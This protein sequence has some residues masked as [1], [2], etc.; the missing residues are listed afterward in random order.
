PLLEALE[1]RL[2]PSASMLTYHNDNS[3]S[4]ENLNEAVLTPAN[5][6]SASFGKLF[7]TSLDG[8]IYAQPL[9]ADNVNVTVGP[10]PGLYNVV[11]VAT[12]HDSLYAIDSNS[13]KIL[14]HDS[15]IN[16][17]AG[18]T[19]VPSNDVN[20]SDLTPEIGITGTPVI[21]ATTN[22]LYLDAKTKEV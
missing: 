20:S 14:W 11:Y 17:S 22:T 16:P 13:G 12:E 21:D 5:V 15:F 2:A 3:S 7:K 1:E 6:N 4:G 8:Q 19:T 9:Y 10:S 18:V